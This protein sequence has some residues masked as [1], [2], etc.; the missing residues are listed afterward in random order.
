MRV[1]DESRQPRDPGGEG[2]GQWVESGASALGDWISGAD[3]GLDY[4]DTLQTI[5]VAGG[6]MRI[7]YKPSLPVEA[8]YSSGDILVGPK[9]FELPEANRRFVVAHEIGHSFDSDLVD[10]FPDL[11]DPV[12][13]E[14]AEGVVFG[15]PATNAYERVADAY[16]ALGLPEGKVEKER[17]PVFSVVEEYARRRGFPLALTAAYNPLQPRD[18]GGE[19]GGQWVESG[20]SSV[21]GRDPATLETA[22]VVDYVAGRLGGTVLNYTGT[23]RDSISGKRILTS[24][25]IESPSGAIV[26]LGVEL[27]DYHDRRNRARRVAVLH[28]FEVVP[29]RSGVGTQVMEA[30]K[31]FADDTGHGVAVFQAATVAEP[32]YARFPWLTGFDE[33]DPRLSP[34]WREAHPAL[35][36]AYNPSQPRHPGGGPEGGQWMAVG[37]RVTPVYDRRPVY[38]TVVEPIFRGEQHKDD[39]SV[40]WDDGRQQKH[41][42]FEV[43]PT[44]PG[45]EAQYAPKVEVPKTPAMIEYG[46]PG[47]PPY[48]PMGVFVPEGDVKFWPRYVGDY[49]GEPLWKGLV[50]KADQTKSV[51][52]IAD[53]RGSPSH[54]TML[55]ALQ[56]AGVPT[57]LPADVRWDDM[58]DVSGFGRESITGRLPDQEAAVETVLREHRHDIQD[59]AGLVR[60]QGGLAAAGFDPTKHPHRPGGN[61]HGGE[62]A[63]THFGPGD[64]G[65]PRRFPDGVFSPDADV[66]FW[67]VEIGA[68]TMGTKRWHP[69]WKALVSRDGLKRVFWFTDPMG[70]PHHEQMLDWFQ[71]GGDITKAVFDPFDHP[72]FLSGFGWQNQYAARNGADHP[73]A[74]VTQELTSKNGDAIAE[75]QRIVNEERGPVGLAASAF[76]PSKHP[77]RPGGDEHGGEWARKEERRWSETDWVPDAVKKWAGTG[78]YSQNAVAGTWSQDPDEL[79]FD[80]FRPTIVGS[81]EEH[82]GGA[83]LFPH[84][85]DVIHPPRE[86]RGGVWWKA[87]YYIPTGDLRVWVPN[88][89]GG[90]HHLQVAEVMGWEGAG[91]IRD[92]GRRIDIM[93]A[94]YGP[95]AS[96]ES[97]TLVNGSPPGVDHPAYVK[98][99][100]FMAQTS[101]QR[102]LKAADEMA[103]GEIGLAASAADPFQADWEE[104]QRTA[105]SHLDDLQAAFEKAL[106]GQRRAIVKAYKLTNLVAAGWDPAKHPH[107]PGGSS[108]GGQWARK[109][110]A[111]SGP[112]WVQAVGE[113]TDADR[114]DLRAY[115][116]EQQTKKVRDA[117]DAGVTYDP[118]IKGMWLAGSWPGSTDELAFAPDVPAIEGGKA[119]WKAI[120]SPSG[121]WKFWVTNSVGAPHHFTVASRLHWPVPQGFASK[122]TTKGFSGFGTT[123]SPYELE[124]YAQMFPEESVGWKL[125]D[126]NGLSDLVRRHSREILDA[127]EMALAAAAEQPGGNT[128][129]SQIIDELLFKQAMIAAARAAQLLIV[130]SV[131][132]SI[133]A[134]PKLARLPIYE[135]L[136]ADVNVVQSQ[137]AFEAV[138]DSVNR[139]LLES[140][141][142]GWDV[143][144]TAVELNTVLTDFAPWQATRLA[145]TSLISLANG[146]SLLAAQSLGADGPTFKTWL[147]AGD[148]LVRP[149]HVEA[150]RQTV[151]TDQ[152]FNV[153]GVPMMFPGDPSAPDALKQNC[154]CTLVYG[155]DPHP[156]LAYS[157]DWLAP[158]GELAL[159][160][161]FDPAKHPR[162]PATGRDDQ[163]SPSDGGKFAAKGGGSSTEKDDWKGD[164][165]SRPWS[166]TLS[167]LDEFTKADVIA[168]KVPGIVYDEN[169]R[170]GV[171]AHARGVSIT[172]GKNSF[173]EN[174]KLDTLLIAHEAG[175]YVA[176]EIQ[177]EEGELSIP[178]L[179][180]FRK[181][182]D[183]ELL[184]KKQVNG[185]E[186]WRV[187][188]DGAEMMIFPPTVAYENPFGIDNKP[189]EILA[190]TYSELLH[191]ERI[192]DADVKDSSGAG[193]KRA[194]LDRVARTAKKMGLPSGRVYQFNDKGST[195]TA[196]FDPGKHPRHPAGS[197]AGGEFAPKLFTYD[198]TRAQ[199]E[200]RSWV[201]R[202]NMDAVYTDESVTFLKERLD[203]TMQTALPLLQE[204]L[205]AAGV[206]AWVS[207]QLDMDQIDVLA[208]PQATFSPNFDVSL[209]PE[210]FAPGFSVWT[211]ADG[212]VEVEDVLDL[213]DTDFFPAGP[214][215]PLAQNYAKLVDAAGAD[216][217]RPDTVTLYRGMSPAEMDAWKAGEPVPSGKFFTDKPTVNYAQDQ[218]GVFPEL[219]TFEVP[220]SS[221]MRTGPNEFQ[222][223][224]P[225]RLVDGRLAPVSAR[226]VPVDPGR[227][228]AAEGGHPRGWGIGPDYR[229]RDEMRPGQAPKHG[230]RERARDAL[231]RRR[232]LTAAFDESKVSRQPSGTRVGG[233]FRS[234]TQPDLVGSARDEAWT[235][236][237]IAPSILTGAEMGGTNVDFTGIGRSDQYWTQHERDVAARAEVWGVTPEGYKDMIAHQLQQEAKDPLVIRTPM[238]GYDGAD[239][240]LD[241]IESGRFMA[242]ME[243]GVSQGAFAPDIRAMQEKLF[244][245]YSIDMAPE[246]RPIYGMVDSI[247][248]HS[249][250]HNYGDVLWVLKDDIRTRTTVTGIDSLSRPVVPGPI[251]NPGWRATVPPGYDG[252]VAIPIH[253]QFADGFAGNPDYVEAQFHGG[254]SLKDV[255]HVDLINQNPGAASHKAHVDLLRAKLAPHG[256]TVRAY[257]DAYERDWGNEVVWSDAVIRETGP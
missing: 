90:P 107:E 110:A 74:V 80:G 38:G 142:E 242:Q 104:G 169:L 3:P 185:T 141:V 216:P 16:A 33:Y 37:T 28:D 48:F 126:P 139:V 253:D 173:L 96:F 174:G 54:G 137:A 127:Q 218:A 206:G 196:A 248:S 94:G 235:G 111:L 247:E 205:D 29:Q 221:V 36:A 51:F 113:M 11:M 105:A 109:L 132:L 26:T 102:Q 4:I 79:L 170:E 59:A 159:S 18:P 191:Q 14:D 92:F 32:F 167:H 238:Y 254:V 62:F 22:D 166:N 30:L 7:R 91:Q 144:D 207:P 194:L 176:N 158:P 165:K 49:G 19:G 133:A 186:K 243:S 140:L 24:A 6:E 125:G 177:N 43:R 124:K 181:P 239:P 227:Y 228:P 68:N 103:R 255:D 73:L 56:V 222:L 76:D 65:F 119:L 147:T 150:D 34:E 232:V 44:R 161:A 208:N 168:G 9:F 201:D 182:Y 160:A 151:P 5:D 83:R 2:G 97:E 27:T 257:E 25:M 116:A 217:G 117:A 82:E 66:A 115:T 130:E 95:T 225:A 45:E 72:H 220:R 77:H 46:E 223:S 47:F 120:R 190:D 112:E 129:S 210:P 40:A 70:A 31:G 75:A 131:V 164:R 99:R 226:I 55:S 135:M 136:L 108:K 178:E 252:N 134:D 118:A 245:G 236:P 101:V 23:E 10:E 231:A 42:K 123:V 212:H 213:G 121:E 69:L 149:T 209:G 84:G 202:L 146:S 63:P 155:S 78:M 52:W 153:D 145:R 200:M 89:M 17:W 60:A 81:Y 148:E 234:A 20:A 88:V 215:S 251:N 71:G 154:R 184:E 8:S 246:L 152:P 249:V 114:R 85:E 256:I 233:Q 193:P 13:W 98:L 64:A 175:H 197:E 15:G 122:F 162:N 163:E 241:I 157:E 179:E 219:Q 53:R 86:P 230:V 67:P 214:E 192:T 138:S 35:T 21:A 172:M 171:A 187:R 93:G 203:G 198:D 156:L 143:P 58:I 180:P 100:E 183:F 128:P 250:A 224:Q 188:R 57:G 12:S 240:A 61:E 244:F 50:L 41:L 195:L 39:V 229:I 204:R 1:W 211:F 199:T 237:P 87:S 189:E 106:H